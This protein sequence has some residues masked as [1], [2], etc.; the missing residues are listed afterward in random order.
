MIWLE[1]MAKKATNS[2]SQYLMNRVLQFRHLIIC[3]NRI[4][5]F[6]YRTFDAVFVAFLATHHFYS[7]LLF[8]SDCDMYD[9]TENVA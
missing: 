2:A 7:H 4:T 1:M 3:L 8:N 9:Y 5:L 6:L